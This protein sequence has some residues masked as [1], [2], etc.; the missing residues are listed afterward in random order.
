M[1]DHKC[2]QRAA[3]RVRLISALVE[4]RSVT[5]APL[6]N[7]VMDASGTQG[8]TVQ[9]RR[10]TFLCIT[11]VLDVPTVTQDGGLLLLAGPWEVVTELQP[12][13]TAD[14]CLSTGKQMERRPCHMLPFTKV[15]LDTLDPPDI[16]HFKR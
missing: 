3:A 16:C 15:P 2:S 4:S 13:F 8:E 1:S 14:L 6:G 5:H 9:R 11:S 12:L 10:G 7:N